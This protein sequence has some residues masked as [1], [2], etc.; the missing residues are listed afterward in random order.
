MPKILVVDDSTDLLKVFPLIFKMSGYEVEAVSSK[1][2]LN[3][4]LAEFVP[5]VVLLDVRLSGEDGRELCKEIKENHP[6]N[7]PVIL[8]S[9]SPE[10]LQDYEA[11]KADAVIEKPFNIQ[12]LLKKVTE[13]LN[14]Y[15]TV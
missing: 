1:D 12:T 6:Q 15:Q 4:A 9:A 11:C 8:T 5:D 13:V 10:L 2:K 7:I 14:K 3:K